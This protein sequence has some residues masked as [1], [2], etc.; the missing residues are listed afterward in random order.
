MLPDYAPTFWLCAVPAVMMFGMAKG[1][2]GTGIGV[3][4]TPLLT[5]AIP[6]TD[7]VA[8]LLPLL[9]IADLFAVNQ[10]RMNFHRRSIKLLLP[11]AFFGIAIGGIFFS[12]FRGNERILQVAIGVLA[13]WFVLFQVFRAII[14]GALEKRRPRAFEG[15]L[16]G[17][18]SGFTST[19]AHAGG[20]P[21]VMHL[22][23][24][25]FPRDLFVGTMVIYF[26]VVNM[27][28]LIP[29]QALGLLKVGNLTTIIVLAPLTY[30]G[31][32]LGIYLN[33]RFTDLWFNRMVYTILVFTGLQLVTGQNIIAMLLR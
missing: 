7:A 26:A 20:P 17:A 8:I 33:R 19:L 18:I 32:R 3:I 12:F 24:Q 23:P 10:Y 21:A 4:A 25:K 16:M 9:I 29:Y 2:F 31:V 13:L 30:V 1:G 28:K 15:I 6:A 22:L 5:L 27:V 11:G 14:V